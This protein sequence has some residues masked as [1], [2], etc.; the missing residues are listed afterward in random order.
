MLD[1][2]LL[3]SGW[4]RLGFLVGGE[5]AVWADL[6]RASRTIDAYALGLAGYLTVCEREGIDPVTA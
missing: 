3:D 4:V 2:G 5:R 6:G 1:T